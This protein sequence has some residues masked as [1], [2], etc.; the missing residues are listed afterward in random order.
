MKGRDFLEILDLSAEELADLLELSDR[1]ADQPHLLSQG[2]RAR[3][4]AVALVF[5]DQQLTYSQ[6]NSRANHLAWYLRQQHGVGPEVCV[7]LCVERSVEMVVGLAA[8]PSRARRR[9]RRNSAS[10]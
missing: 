10:A 6:L 1:L 5:E 4:D 3:G 7:G 9:P 8:A 2:R